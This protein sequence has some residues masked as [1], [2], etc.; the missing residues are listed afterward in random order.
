MREYAVAD[1]ESARKPASISLIGLHLIAANACECGT[2][3]NDA[4]Q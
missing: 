2:P 3:S 1:P 4:G